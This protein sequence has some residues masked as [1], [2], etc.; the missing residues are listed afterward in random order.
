M[1][2]LS[3]ADVFIVLYAAMCLNRFFTGLLGVDREEKVCSKKGNE[4]KSFPEDGY[5]TWGG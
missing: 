5:P 1:L 3:L 2:I 4:M